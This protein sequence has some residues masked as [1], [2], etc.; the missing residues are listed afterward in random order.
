MQVLILCGEFL[1]HIPCWLHLHLGSFCYTSH[2]GF[3]YTS[4]LA[5]Y[6]LMQGVSRTCPELDLVL[7]EEVLLTSSFFFSFLSRF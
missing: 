6:I 5:C 4:L 2:A 7:F 3:T 1:L